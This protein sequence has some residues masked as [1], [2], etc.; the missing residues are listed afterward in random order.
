MY[1]HMIFVSILSLKLDFYS[2][3]STKRTVE[4]SSLFSDLP[5]FKAGLTK[6]SSL[7]ASA[8]LSYQNGKGFWDLYNAIQNDVNCEVIIIDFLSK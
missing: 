3:L 2:L 7:A 6:L 4:V 1:V 8:A 5:G